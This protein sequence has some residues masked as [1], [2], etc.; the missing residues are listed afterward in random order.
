[1]TARRRHELRGSG[2][3]LAARPFVNAR[4]V[5]RVAIAL[6]VL[7]ALLAA[8]A[9]WSF[10][11]YYSGRA[12]LRRELAEIEASRQSERAVIASLR[13]ELAGV[14]LDNQNQR[15]RFLNQRIAERTFSWSLLFDRLAEIL[16]AD[17]R[18]LSL[19]PRVDFDPP[20]SRRRSR[21][22]GEEDAAA[23]ELV[24]LQIQAVSRRDEAIL[25]LLDAMF[26]SP[27]F[28]R[29]NL[30]QETRQGGAEVRFTLEVGY[31]PESPAGT[32]VE[33]AGPSEPAPGP[34]EAPPAAGEEGAT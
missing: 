24:R 12:D 20:E 4:P 5:V 29:P 33:A 10:W 21:R 32:P 25:E 34:D 27:H 3:N 28:E 30:H 23:G 6:W 16:P 9:G 8:A 31:L 22:V 2:V 1:M 26:A 17:V 15:V 11:G 13:G 14:A 19:T 18:L 7:G